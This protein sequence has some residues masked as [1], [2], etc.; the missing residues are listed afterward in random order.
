MWTVS[1]PNLLSVF[2]PPVTLVLTAMML[3]SQFDSLGAYL[4]IHKCQTPKKSLKA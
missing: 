1:L 4:V 2:N 3:P